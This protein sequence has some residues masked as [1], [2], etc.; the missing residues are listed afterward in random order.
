MS[1]DISFLSSADNSADARLHRIVSSLIRGGLSCEVR[2]RGNAKDAPQGSHFFPSHNGSGFA[3]RILRDLTLPFVAKG[4]IW[5]VDS[6]DLLITAYLLGRLR[7]RKVVA[8][9]RED[10]RR[11]LKDRAWTKSLF[12]FAGV[13]GQFAATLSESV[14]KRVDLTTVADVQVPPF[15]AKQRLLL[16]NL[17]DAHISAIQGKLSE[18]PTAIYIGDVRTSRGL[19]TMLTA[20]EGAPQWNF[21]IIGNLADE[22]STFVAEWSAT[23]PEVAARVHFR[24][25]MDPVSSWRYAESAWVG[26]T[27]LEST[28]AFVDAVPSK[29]YE[30][31]AAGL[32]IISSPLPRCVELINAS[33][34]GVIA[35]SAGEVAA[36]LTRLENDSEFLSRLRANGATWAAANL[37][38][39]GEYGAF[40]AAIHS[41]NR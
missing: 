38:S 39:A 4:D 37:D 13:A 3:K 15:K 14:A 24:G 2:T 32:A 8:D 23:H 25:R 34:S 40:V 41:L 11:L 31:M 19:R 33:Q 7:G 21:E 12:G 18:T 30:Y 29:L 36:A 16:R 28:P 27:L 22:D 26:L 35:V 10:Y 1:V 6:P 9:I 20:A 17:P 5:I